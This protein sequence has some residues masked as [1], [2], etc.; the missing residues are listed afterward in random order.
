[1]SELFKI[2]DVVAGY[3]ND[4][5]PLVVVSATVV[6]ATPKQWRIVPERVKGAFGAFDYR[7]TVAPGS[8][9]TTPQ[10]AIQKFIARQMDRAASHRTLAESLERDAALASALLAP[11][12]SAEASPVS[13]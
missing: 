3:G 13:E 9:A 12:A 7:M 1:V 2:Y 8:Y 4:V 6:K 5:G 10:D 11:Y